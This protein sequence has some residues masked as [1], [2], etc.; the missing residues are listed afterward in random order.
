MILVGWCPAA[1]DP[2]DLDA[3]PNRRSIRL[4]IGSLGGVMVGSFEFG[5][6]GS[7]VSL[8]ADATKLTNEVCVT[9]LKGLKSVASASCF[10]ESF[11]AE[12]KTGTYNISLLEYPIKPYMNN[13]VYH[14]GNPRSNLFSC[15][16]S[17]VDEE[18][19]T[20][21]YCRI[22]DISLSNL[23]GKHYYC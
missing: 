15:N 23:P 5:F 6:G 12:K 20:G 14:D 16:I 22:D 1:F 13:I 2:I 4:E 10:R 19:A 17:K 11:D 7:A 8:N 3:K 21:P 18:E 9:A